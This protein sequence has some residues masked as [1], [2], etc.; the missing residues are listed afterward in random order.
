MSKGANKSR[1]PNGSAG[2]KAALRMLQIELVKVQRHVIQHGHK[3]LVLIEGRDASLPIR[4]GSPGTFS[5]MSR[6]CL[7]RRN[8]S[9]SI[10]AGTI[11]Q[12]SNG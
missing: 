12:A 9:F 2:Y 5:A 6:T 10:A 1:D 7:R 4:I 3:V 8:W 11:A